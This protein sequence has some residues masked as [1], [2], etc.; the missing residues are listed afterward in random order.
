[1]PSKCHCG[2]NAKSFFKSIDGNQHCSMTCLEMKGRVRSEEAIAKLVSSDGSGLIVL[3]IPTHRARRRDGAASDYDDDDDDNNNERGSHHRMLVRWNRFLPLLV[4]EMERADA[5][6]CHAGAGALLEALEISASSFNSTALFVT[7]I[8]FAC[9]KRS[10]KMTSTKAR[11]PRLYWRKR[12][13]SMLSIGK[14]VL[15]L[16]RSRHIS[17]GNCGKD[18]AHCAGGPQLLRIRLSQVSS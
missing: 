13:P 4:S 15:A 10:R 2:K 18:Q 16:T 3:L 7:V 9:S 1:M 6:L 5:I 11:P 12:L 17:F 14:E 8:L